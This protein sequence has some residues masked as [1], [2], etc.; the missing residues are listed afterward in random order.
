MNNGEHTMEHPTHK[1]RVARYRLVRHRELPPEH[2][3]EYL[4]DGINP[5]DMW[6]LVWSFTTLEAAEKQLA[7]EESEKWPTETW[8][9]ID[10]GTESV[11]ERP[12][13]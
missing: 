8:K 13:W 1:E 5:D 2:K 11:I 7:V 12:I 3:A 6:S 4:R 9:I 10:N